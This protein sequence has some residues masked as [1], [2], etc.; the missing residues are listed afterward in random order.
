MNNFNKKWKKAVLTLAIMLMTTAGAWAQIEWN[1]TQT[2]VFN[3]IITENIVLTGGTTVNVGS[4]ITVLI[5]GNINGGIH[6]LTK[7]GGGA[8]TITGN[9]GISGGT[10]IS[11]GVLQI[12]N[13]GTTGQW[14]G[15]IVNNGS[16]K[17]NRSSLY[18]HAGNISGS[19]SLTKNGAHLTLTGNLTYTG[20]TFVENGNLQIGN[21]TNG[22]GLNS[23]VNLSN[24]SI[25]LRFEPSTNITYSK[26]I[27]GQGKVEYKGSSSKILSLT[28]NNSHTGTTTVEAGGVLI[29][30]DYPSS[31]TGSIAGDIILNTG[32]K[33]DFRR[34]NNYIY[35][36]AI[37]GS[38]SVQKFLSSKVT[39]TGANNYT[40]STT[41][42][43][44]TLQI[45]NGTTTN[46]NINSTSGITIN[47]GATLRFELATNMAISK[48]ISGAGK[49]EFTSDYKTLYLT[50]NNTYTGTTTI[51]KGHLYIGDNGTTG[52][53]KG[54][55]IIND[56]GS[57]LIFRRSNAYT[58]SGV[59]SGVGEVCKYNSNTVTLNGNNT[60]TGTTTIYEGT[61]VL[62]TNGRIENSKEV[63]LGADNNSKFDVSAGNKK[64]R[65]I[66]S[67][68]EKHEL[69]LGS[70]TL[71]IGT[72]GQEDEVSRLYG[73]ITGTGGIT[74][75]GTGIVFMNSS[76]TAT[77][78]FTHSQGTVSIEGS[79]TKWDGNYN[80]Q[81]NG[82]LSFLK[83]TSQF[84]IGGNFT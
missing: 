76:H 33:L 53:I 63:I 29:I 52:D 70:T 43:A 80:L 28:G 20:T 6:T 4:G 41:V 27:S 78:T 15:N 75:Q 2:F 35:S 51:E 59:I 79:N 72:A 21:G 50:A 64:I 74:K 37:L 7:T 26:V 49:V 57:R 65:A 62:G 84:T 19:G 31:T 83:D 34:S 58:Y 46:T 22:G 32:A 11:D 12:G 40:G 67:M 42:D 17:F 44:G 61:L 30:G 8:M 16:L 66:R 71:T 9:C 54:N 69:V 55:I 68:Y 18:V 73:K 47:S 13:G 25:V 45:G 60:Y 77:G 36:G 10:T 82:I 1:G 38:G 23:N 24:S 14:S 56:A 5:T 48:I 3:T 81:S 39:L